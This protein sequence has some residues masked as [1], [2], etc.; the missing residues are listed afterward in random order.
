LGDQ[1]FGP[2]TL[3]PTN[4]TDE[5]MTHHSKV[6]VYVLFAIV[7]ALGVFLLGDYWIAGPILVVLLLCAYPQSYETTPKA[8]LVR[9]ALNRLVIPY[10]T[11]SFIGPVGEEE[12]GF[13][14]SSNHI[15]IQYG[16]ASDILITPANCRAF[17]ADIAK[18]T[19]H[20]T[21]RGQRLTAVFA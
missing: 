12:N 16:L 10:E 7:M 11:I 8:L 17:F 21:K 15:R 4:I 13:A 14:M 9:R 20:L 19:P 2:V 6:D 3:T 5:N 1:A 18:Y